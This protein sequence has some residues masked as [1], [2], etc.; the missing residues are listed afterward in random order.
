VVFH[1]HGYLF[2]G[3]AD[4]TAAFAA[5]N[6]LQRSLGVDVHL[7]DAPALRQRFPWLNTD[8]VA[9]GSFMGR[10]EGW[11]DGYTLLNAFKRR[12]RANGVAYRHAEV[13]DLLRE[14]DRVTG[15]RCADGST[16][17]APV[18]VNAAGAGGRGIA[19]LAGIALPIRNIKQSVFAFESPFRVDG[20][21]FVLAQDRLFFRPEGSGYIVGLGIDDALPGEIADYDVD[22][23]VFEDRIW[24][25]LAARVPG[26]AQLRVRSAWSGHYDMNLFDHNAI[27]G[28]VP[29]RDGFYL[30]NGFSGHG[31]MQSPG[32]GRALSELIVYGA[33]RTLDLSDLSF[34]RIAANRPV[35]ENIQY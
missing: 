29:G 13:A 1:Q 10:G 17:A 34:E 15:V 4:A 21:P 8:D 14:G 27:V 19:A 12:A 18:V 33:Y 23:A 7:L 5:N 28:R 16:I 24:P 2:L 35:R 31:V 32:I 20:M 25:L 26:F 22:H 30:A 6:R 11:I 3:G 9:V